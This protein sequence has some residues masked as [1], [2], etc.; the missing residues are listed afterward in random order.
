MLN[1]PVCRK[2]NSQDISRIILEAKTFINIRTQR[3]DGNLFIQPISSG[4]F[5]GPL[6]LMRPVTSLSLVSPLLLCGVLTY[7]KNATFCLLFVWYDK[8]LSESRKGPLRV[9]VSNSSSNEWGKAVMSWRFDFEV[10]FT[11]LRNSNCRNQLCSCDYLNLHQRFSSKFRSIVKQVKWYET[12][13]L[14]GPL[15]HAGR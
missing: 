12:C 5:H 15:S 9:L 2:R 1:G 7:C 3:C 6:P 13:Q 8:S 11:L 10:Q 4:R 14:P